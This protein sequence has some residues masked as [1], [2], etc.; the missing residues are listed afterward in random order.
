MSLTLYGKQAKIVAGWLAGL[1]GLALLVCLGLTFYQSTAPESFADCHKKIATP[2]ASSMTDDDKAGVLRIDGM[3][4]E[5]VLLSGR[6]CLV[7]AGV[8]ATTSDAAADAKRP[9]VPISLFLNDRLVP[10][11]N[12]PAA[13]AKSAAQLLTFE[14]SHSDS[15]TAD[16]SKFWR[17]LLAGKAREGLPEFSVGI[18][19]APTTTPQEPAVRTLKIRV[20]SGLPLVFGAAAMVLLIAAFVIFAANSTVLRDNTLRMLASKTLADTKDALVT[21]EAAKTTADKAQTAAD[22][23]KT[24]ADKAK[25]GAAAPDPI[26]EQAAKDAAAA[27]GKAADEVRMAVQAVQI[28]ANKVKRFEGNPDQPVGTFSLGRTQMALWLGLATAGFV[29]LWLTLGFYLDVM[30]ASILVLIGINGATGLAA[31]AID[32]PAAGAAPPPQ[33]ESKGFLLDL[34]CDSNGPQMHR[35]QVV[36]WTC[37]LGMIF[38]WNTVWNF[39]FVNFD[40]NLLLLMG[41]AN[42]MYLG[43]K[44]GEKP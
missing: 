23:A 21:A 31:I 10:L 27:A 41:I 39:I 25:A 44:P 30:T 15:A 16:A 26:L 13:V 19:R 6:L 2:P 32:K 8:A 18:S 24:A 42:A 1:G 33:A 36:V 22:N 34:V 38:V 7:I 12:K 43:F 20:Y 4:P 35:I 40:T 37:I 5:T 28:A 17:D 14:F 29:F 11:V 3:W 9:P